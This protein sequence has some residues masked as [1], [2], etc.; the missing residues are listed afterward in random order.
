MEHHLTSAN[1]RGLGFWIEIGVWT[2]AGVAILLVVG[3]YL[4][5]HT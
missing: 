5:G 2:V 1:K 3:F 4:G